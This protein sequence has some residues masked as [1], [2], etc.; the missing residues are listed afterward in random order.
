MKE[1]VKF[2]TSKRSIQK[3]QKNNKSNNYTKRIT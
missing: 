3:I 2:D 1:K